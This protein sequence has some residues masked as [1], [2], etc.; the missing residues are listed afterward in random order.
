MLFNYFYED[1]EDTC[2]LSIEKIIDVSNI[3]PLINPEHIISIYTWAGIL[4]ENKSLKESEQN[5]LIA[6]LSLHKYY[7]D[8]RGRGCNGHPWELFITWRLSLLSR[9]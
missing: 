6:L 1:D 9:L 4:Q 2:Y 3:S 8:P 7:Q 5:Y